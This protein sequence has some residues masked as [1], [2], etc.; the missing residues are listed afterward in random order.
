MHG[1]WKLRLDL[2]PQLGQD[3]FQFLL[4]IGFLFTSQDFAVFFYLVKKILSLFN[5]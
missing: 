5:S 2:I 4:A 1:C 3:P